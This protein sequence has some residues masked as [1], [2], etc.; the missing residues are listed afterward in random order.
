MDNIVDLS[1]DDDDGNVSPAAW[2]FSKEAEAA[3]NDRENIIHRINTQFPLNKCIP[4]REAHI[5]TTRGYYNEHPKNDLKYTND[6]GGGKRSRRRVYRDAETGW[7]W[8]EM[9]WYLSLFHKPCKQIK[10]LHFDR[11]HDAKAKGSSEILVQK[12]D[13][14]HQEN[15]KVACILKDKINWE[16]GSFNYRDFNV[17]NH[18]AHF[19]ADILPFVLYHRRSKC[20]KED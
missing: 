6:G 7:L 20:K 12:K 11:D 15:G 1:V 19:W 5:N 13:I 17:T 3:M 14:E 8:H 16:E 9:P 10:L 18:F 2:S 4:S